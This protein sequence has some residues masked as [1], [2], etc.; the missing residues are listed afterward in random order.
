MAEQLP[1]GQP[2]EMVLLGLLCSVSV[3]PQEE[4][5]LRSRV[6]GLCGEISSWEL[7]LRLAAHHKIAPLVAHATALSKASLPD[8]VA[9]SLRSRAAENTVEA[10][11]YLVELDRIQ[12]LLMSSGIRTIALKGVPLSVSAFGNLALRDVGDIDLLIDPSDAER[13][14]TILRE[15]GLKRH[16]P[17][18]LLTRR[19]RSFYTR[20]HK[21]YTYSAETRG[22]EIDLHWRLLRDRRASANIM[23]SVHESA[24]PT[25]TIG[26]IEI[27]VLTFEQCVVYLAVHGAMEGWARWKSLVDIAALWT[28]ATSTQHAAAWTLA[29]RSGSAP[30]LSASLSLADDWLRLPIETKNEERSAPSRREASRRTYILSHTRRQMVENHF[31]PSPAGP[32]TLAMK[33]HEIRLRPSLR[34][35]RDLA[36]RILFRTRMWERIDL[37]DSLFFIYPLL[38]PF[39]W[40]F[41]RVRDALK[42]SAQ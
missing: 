16:E 4:E 21:D 23:E 40:I 31:M 42:G 36:M 27:P 5:V 7:F 18:A 12:G 25:L 11:R 8:H 13:A 38:S 20:F 6:A 3:S 28:K 29:Q 10:F 22:F 34:S 17:S 33:W 37:P 41:F 9:S 26:D 2:P 24:H 15:S 35:L 1:Y 30:F 14:D 19:R 39:E 32:T